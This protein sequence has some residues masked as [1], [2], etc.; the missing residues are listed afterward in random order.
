MSIEIVSAD[1]PDRV[2]AAL[3]IRRL[4][5][6]DEQGVSEAEEIDGLDADAEHLLA[7]D[8]SGRAVGT[9]RM[10]GLSERAARIGRMAVVAE[11]RGAGV[12]AALLAAA[13]E[14][15]RSRGFVEVRLDAQ[16]AAAPFYRRAGYSQHGETFIDA[17]IE[18]IAMSRRLA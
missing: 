4:V 9:C 8:E 2:E 16:V 11:A 18:H 13:E 7:I 15:L 1:R 17:G 10:L 5:F 6:I 12:G 14:R 3:T